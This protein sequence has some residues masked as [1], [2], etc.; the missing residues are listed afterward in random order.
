MVVR[1]F[2]QK[3]PAKTNLSVAAHLYLKAQEIVSSEGVPHD[4]GYP[5]SPM[6]KIK[7]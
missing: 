1:N 6:Q 4:F 5:E 3:P 2:R 7:Y